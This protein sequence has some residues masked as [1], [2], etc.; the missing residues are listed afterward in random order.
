M[1]AKFIIS[2]IK[3]NHFFRDKKGDKFRIV[4]LLSLIHLPEEIID[5]CGSD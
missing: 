3:M 4:S 1:F 5:I 2:K